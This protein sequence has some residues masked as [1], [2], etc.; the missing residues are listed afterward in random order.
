M[1]L[2]LLRRR[3]SKNK[4]DLYCLNC[5]HSFRTDNKFKSQEKV[6]EEKHFCVIALPT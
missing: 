5:M 6:C 3:A 2:D 1:L 4:G